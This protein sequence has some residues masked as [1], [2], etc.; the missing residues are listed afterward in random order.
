METPA[1]GQVLA[2][3]DLGA[4]AF[5]EDDWLLVAIFPMSWKL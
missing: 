1:P 4:A 5:L 2:D 3:F